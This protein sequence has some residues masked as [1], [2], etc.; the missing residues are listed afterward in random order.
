MW[1]CGLL[2]LC[3]LRWSKRGMLWFHGQNSS[4]VSRGHSTHRCTIPVTCHPQ[5]CRRQAPLVKLW[6]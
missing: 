5:Q 2:K 3:S 4:P 1:L 6:Q